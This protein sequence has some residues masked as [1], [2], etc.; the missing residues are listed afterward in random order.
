[1]QNSRLEAEDKASALRAAIREP[2]AACGRQR[3]EV[4]RAA[5]AAVP[6]S[7]FAYLLSDSLRKLFKDLPTF[8]AVGDKA[9]QGM[10]TAD[11][12]RWVRVWWESLPGEND[13]AYPV[14]FAKGGAFSSFYADLPLAVRRRRAQVPE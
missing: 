10:A 7:P 12:F 6:R 3:F 11:D 8:D 9:K 13:D 2:E 1:V 14:P 4:E 5:F